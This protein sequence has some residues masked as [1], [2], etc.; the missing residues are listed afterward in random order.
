MKEKDVDN[1]LK[2]SSSEY[3]ELLK[4]M[5]DDFHKICIRNNLAYF[6]AF[7]TLIGTV[8]HDGFIPWDDDIDVCMPRDDYEQLISII[9]K[10]DSPYYMLTP[11][12]SRYYYN[13]FSRFCSKKGFLTLHGIIDIDNLGPFIDVIPLDNVTEDEN[14]RQEYYQRVRELYLLTRYSLPGRYF[15]TLTL[16]KR[17]KMYLNLPKRIYARLMGG[18]EGIKKQKEMAIEKYRNMPTGLLSA[19]FDRLSDILLIRSEEIEEL[20]LHPFEDIEVMIPAKYDQIL[21][22]IYGDYMKLPP[23][24][25]QVPKHHFIPYWK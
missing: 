5:L 6:V 1:E 21:K 20:L 7:G 24:D 11:G 16:K 22:R 25:Q 3:K 4:D 9:E 17:L 13:N 12:N 15:K 8:R 18:T 23:I 14:K 10:E 2:I 19:S